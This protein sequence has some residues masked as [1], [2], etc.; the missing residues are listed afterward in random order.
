L[1]Q[2]AIPYLSTGRYTGIDIAP[3]MIE[4]AKRKCN[5]VPTTCQV[6]WLVQTDVPFTYSDDSV[7]MI[8]AYSVFTHMEHEDSYRYLKDAL[9]IVKP[10]GKFL[11][12][13]LLI[14]TAYGADIF[15]GAARL[16]L[17]ERWAN[18]RNIVTS[19][20]LMTAISAKANWQVLD[21]RQSLSGQTLCVL[22]KK[23]ETT[24]K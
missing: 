24:A 23:L 12:T 15:L 20:D 3:T 13:C 21:W 1:A 9:R 22:Q 10:G 5:S 14:D 4:R 2:F 7:D 16:T 6:E 18:P 19:K 17:A 8:C 11:Y